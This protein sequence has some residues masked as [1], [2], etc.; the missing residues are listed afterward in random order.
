MYVRVTSQDMTSI[1]VTNIRNL[2]I[3]VVSTNLMRTENYSNVFCDN[4][5]SR[6]CRQLI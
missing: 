3:N 2:D 5:I 6:F 1:R 4:A